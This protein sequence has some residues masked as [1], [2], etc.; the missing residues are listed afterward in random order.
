MKPSKPTLTMECGCDICIELP[1]WMASALPE[2]VSLEEWLI[3]ASPEQ[4]A[5]ALSPELCDLN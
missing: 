3:A 5:G 4:I 1:A 2:P